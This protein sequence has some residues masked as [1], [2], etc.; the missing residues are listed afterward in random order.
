MKNLLFI[1]FSL[2]ALKASG[3]QYMLSGH[4]SDA[5]NHPVSLV[6]IYISNTTYGTTANESGNY[7]FKLNPGN[8][9]VVYRLVGHKEVVQNVNITSHDVRLNIKMEDEVFVLKTVV[10]EGKRVK[11]DTAADAIMERLIAKR[12]Y[13][14]NEVKQYSCAVYL[15]GVQRLLGAPKAFLG[16]AVRNTLDLDSLGRGILYQS[17]SLSDYSFQQPNHIKEITTALK[18]VWAKSCFQL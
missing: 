18:T 8:Y 10:V 11:T 16:K 12:D 2:I 7:Q 3:Q 17:E 4:I 13:Y 5:E 15:K 9:K 6:S 1:L 14:L